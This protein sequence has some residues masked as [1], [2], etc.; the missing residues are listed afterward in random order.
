MADLSDVEEA[1]LDLITKVAYPAGTLQPSITSKPVKLYRG[2]PGQLGLNADLASGVQTITIFSDPQGA[3]ETTRYPRQWKTGPVVAPTLTATV[4]G[5]S[6]VLGGTGGVGQVVGIA[7]DGAGFAVA[8]TASDTPATLA[9]SLAALIPGASVQASVVTVPDAASLI[10]RVEGSAVSM[11][12][13]RRQEQA[14]MVSIW[15]A[16]PAGRDTLARAVDNALSALDWL[17]LPDGTSGL[18]RYRHTIETDTSENAG[19]YRRD[20]VYGI[21]YPTI[22]TMTSP[23]M[24]FG[25]LSRPG[26]TVEAT[27]TLPALGAI[28]FDAWYDPG[29]TIDVQC[30]AALAPDAWSSRWPPNAV[31]S[32]GVLS[33][34]L[35][36]QATIDAEIGAA[37]A[38]GLSFWAFDSY[39]PADG[40][41]V[42]LTLYLSSALRSALQFCMLGQSSN[43]GDPTTTSGFAATLDRDIGLMTQPGYLTV[44]G[45]RPVYFVLDAPATTLAALPGG[46]AGALAYVRTNVAARGQASPFIVWLS[47]APLTEYDNTVAARAAGADAAGAY[48]TPAGPVGAVPYSMLTDTASADWSGRAGTGFPLVPTAMAGWDPRPLIETPQSFYPIAPTESAANFYEAGTSDAIGD[49]VASLV[50][51]IAANP[52]GC[53]SGLGLVYAWNELAEGGWIMPTYTPNG[54]DLTRVQSIGAALG[55]RARRLDAST[56][57]IA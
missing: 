1:L 52:G 32:D 27:Q 43:W 46:M 57:I 28:R 31:V 29:D 36:T 16:D 51:F 55:A 12:E 23:A 19:L 25:V 44:L 30:A 39:A 13:T 3:R 40:L 37:R 54:P 7:A 53:A 48:C 34:P 42:A 4:S 9:A 8:S 20:L 2:F 15:C 14:V 45:G 49:H 11:L 17:L 41:G 26:V 18:L 21:D 50:D 33:W 6:V 47:A 38:A 35:A 22:Q 56:T 10:A 5:D 24:M